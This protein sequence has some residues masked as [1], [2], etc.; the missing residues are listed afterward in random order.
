MTERRAQRGQ[1]AVHDAILVGSV[2]GQGGMGLS[3]PCGIVKGGTGQKAQK[4]LLPE[5]V[6]M[7]GSLLACLFKI[8]HASSRGRERIILHTQMGIYG[9]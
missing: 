9:R 7:V 1:E 5:L 2:P 8:K 3:K 4:S 6:T